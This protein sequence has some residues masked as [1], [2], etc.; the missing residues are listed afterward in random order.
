MRATWFAAMSWAYRIHV[1]HFPNACVYWVALLVLQ[2]LVLY[3]LHRV[4]HTCG[5]FW[6][7]HVTHHPASELNLT[8]GFRPSVLQ[9]VYRFAWFPPLTLLGFRPEGVSL[10]SA[11]TGSSTGVR[12]ARGS[13]SA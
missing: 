11:G 7:V 5:L 1:T 13:S 2:D 8:V 9:P 10:W 3:F 4:D 12:S 6:A